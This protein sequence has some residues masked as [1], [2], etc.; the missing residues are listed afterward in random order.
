MSIQKGVQPKSTLTASDPL[1]QRDAALQKETGNE[2]GFKIKMNGET[3]DV[4]FTQK[5]AGVVGATSFASGV[6]LRQPIAESPVGNP[7]ANLHD[8]FVKPDQIEH[9]PGAFNR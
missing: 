2:L 5:K 6:P 3:P 8:Q 9:S 1:V 7:D 4:Q